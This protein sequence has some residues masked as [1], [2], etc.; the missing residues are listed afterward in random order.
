LVSPT[1]YTK[2][3][4]TKENSG[5]AT[6][7][8]ANS[9]FSDNWDK[10]PPKESSATLGNN[11]NRGVER[12]ADD[13]DATDKSTGDSSM[14]A[15]IT[16]VGVAL[17]YAVTQVGDVPFSIPDRLERVISS[18]EE[19]QLLPDQD[20][21]RAETLTEVQATT[22]EATTSSNNFPNYGSTVKEDM[23]AQRLLVERDLAQKA[24]QGA[25]RIS[26][27]MES[28]I[29]EVENKL[30]KLE[31]KAEQTDKLL[32]QVEVEKKALEAKVDAAEKKASMIS[33]DSE[34][35]QQV[36]AEIELQKELLESKIQMTEA[37]LAK[38]AVKSE[39]FE[40]VRL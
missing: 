14:L 23:E 13:S 3:E 16:A 31:A 25:E 37:K 4:P 24:A 1:G 11:S 15:G 12:V 26:R 17:L 39:Q 21:D 28:T 27:Q 30:S 34:K 29:K 38:L 2:T 22:T 19:F 6:A 20:S 35:D 40:K 7:T 32:A 5:S 10:I 33:V 36:L 18:L 9:G 8:P